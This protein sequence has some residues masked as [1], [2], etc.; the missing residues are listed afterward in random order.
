MSNRYEGLTVKEADR[1]LVTTISEMLSEAF[2]SIR[3]MPQEE[4]EFVTVERRAN[5][6]ASCIYYAVKNRRRD[7]P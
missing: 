6:I 2:V 1:L 3:E 4:W 5:E 7:G